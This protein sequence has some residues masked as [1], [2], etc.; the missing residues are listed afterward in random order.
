MQIENDDTPEL[1]QSPLSGE[2]SSDGITVRL[3]IYRLLSG[4]DGWVLEVVDHEGTSTVWDALFATDEAAYTEF[5]RTIE[6]EGIV[7]FLE[8]P[9]RI[10]Y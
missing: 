3:E 9:P 8:T 1:E 7:S 4:D 2:F 6:E 10:R 5:C